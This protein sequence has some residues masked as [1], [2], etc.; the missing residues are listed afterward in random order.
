[1]SKI[2]SVTMYQQENAD[3]EHVAREGAP[4]LR[5]REVFRFERV[6]I[7]GDLGAGE[8]FFE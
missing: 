5:E 6:E 3:F 4:L 1:M 2:K 8:P 7:G